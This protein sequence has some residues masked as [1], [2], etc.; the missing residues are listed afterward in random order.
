MSSSRSRR[1]PGRPS[2][3]SPPAHGDREAVIEA[4]EAAV[5]EGVVEL[6][7]SA[8]RFAH[9]LLASICYEQAPVWKRRAVHR[10]LAD[11]VTDVE[12]RARH[13]ALAA[14]ARTRVA[15]DLDAA[16]EQAAARGA[17]ARRGRALRARGRADAGRSCPRA[18]AAPAGGEA[19][20]ACGDAERAVALLEQL[21]ERGPARR[22]ASRRPVRARISDVRRRIRRRLIELCDEALAEAADDDVRSARILASRRWVRLFKADVRGGARR[23]PGALEKAERVGDPALLAIAIARL[24]P[25][26]GVGAPTSLPGCSSEASRSR[27]ARARARVREEP[28]AYAARALLMRLGELDRA[29]RDA[30][31]DGGEAAQRAATRALARMPSGS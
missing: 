5:R 29:A 13:L 28:A 14:E 8:L 3:W 2:S 1:S 15:S 10:A 11:V 19:A 7:D 6:D 31:G 4:L 20:T 23:R 17:P 16:A 9:P 12:E 22:R 30:R 27:S 24:A 18:A 21:L 25:G 26:G